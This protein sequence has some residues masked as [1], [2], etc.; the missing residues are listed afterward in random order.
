MQRAILISSQVTF[1]A[2]ENPNG[3]VLYET[4]KRTNII[5]LEKLVILK[6]KKN[7]HSLVWFTLVWFGFIILHLC[8]KH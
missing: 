7:G 2:L 8:L 5:L 1:Y 4:I 3:S 6:K